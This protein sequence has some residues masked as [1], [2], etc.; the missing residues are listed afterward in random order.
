MQ[1]V[2][3]VIYIRVC[4]VEQ[5]HQINNPITQIYHDKSTRV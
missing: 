3:I 4:Q 2:L 5:T 1:L